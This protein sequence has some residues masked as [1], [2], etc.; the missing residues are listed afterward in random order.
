MKFKHET[1]IITK[2]AWCFLR[3]ENRK[4]AGCVSL[5]EE[6]LEKCWAR[7]RYRNHGANSEK[8]PI[9]DNEIRIDCD[10][11]NFRLE[12]VKEMLTANGY[13]FR[14][15]GFIVEGIYI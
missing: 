7:I 8:Y 14:Q 9:A 15:D 13:T 11:F 12:Q 4:K 1:I 5:N 10:S 6:Q 3:N 2:E